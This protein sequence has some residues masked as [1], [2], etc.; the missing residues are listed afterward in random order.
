MKAGSLEAPAAARMEVVQTDNSDPRWRAFVQAAQPTLFQHPDWATLMQE[1]YGFPARVA[2][3]LEGG[4]VSAG[5][6]YSE[7]EDF[8]GRRRIAGAFADV[9][10]PLGAEAWPT[11][12]AA[13]CAE[14]I[15]W[16]IRSR[17]SPGERALETRQVAVHQTIEL[18]ADR[19]EALA[20][21]RS[22]QRSEVRQALRAGVS[23]KRYDGAEAIEVF[24]PL[25]LRTRKEKHALLPQPR[26][27]FEALAGRY[28]PQRGFVLAAQLDGAVV[29]AELLLTCGDTLYYKFVASDRSALQARPNDFLL[30][31]AIETAAQMGLRRLDLGIAE[32]E[33]LIHFKRKYRASEAPVFAARYIAAAKPAAAVQMERSLVDVTRALAEANVAA[34]VTEA[35]AA[36][37]YRYFV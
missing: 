34:T 31:S 15:P 21:A 35:A 25:H 28:F 27:F 5:L 24:Y 18:P 3:V 14:D 12:E 32:A 11:I 13:L 23:L 1:T 7:V 26:S 30:W 6:P 20:F 17:C 37:L 10:E 22:R 19:E 36:A 4:V 8:R 9:C 29:G 33:S 2:M 16:Q